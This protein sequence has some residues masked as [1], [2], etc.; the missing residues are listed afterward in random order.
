MLVEMRV[1]YVS[2]FDLSVLNR[3]RWF[4]GL[5]R[6]ELDRRDS[7]ISLHRINIMFLLGLQSAPEASSHC[8]CIQSCVGR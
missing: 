8:A 1:G 3:Y 6:V 4:P 2:G 5:E 7:L